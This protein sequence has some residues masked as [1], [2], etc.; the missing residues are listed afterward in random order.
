[1][2]VEITMKMTTTTTMALLIYTTIVRIPMVGLAH[3]M[4]TSIRMV[5]MM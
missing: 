1:M 5:A 3:L 4:L 2:G